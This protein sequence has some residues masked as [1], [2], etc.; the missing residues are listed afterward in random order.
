MRDMDKAGVLDDA[1]AAVKAMRPLDDEFFR[2]VADDPRAVE[3][4]VRAALDDGNIEVESCRAQERVDLVGRR[5]ICADALCRTAD[6][7]LVNVEAQV[8]RQNDDV[9]RVRDHLSMITAAYTA[10][11]TSFGMIP[12]VA[13]VYLAD[14][15]PIGDGLASYTVRR[16][17]LENGRP[18]D[19]GEVSVYANGTADDGSALSKVMAVMCGKVASDY[20]A[21]PALSERV[22]FIRNDEE[23]QRE[24]TDAVEA[25]LES[26]VERR[27][28]AILASKQAEAYREGREEGL[29]KGLEKGLEQGLEQ[30]Q[31]K[32]QVKAVLDMFWSGV[33]PAPAAAEYLRGLG[34]EDASAL[35]DAGPADGAQ[36]GAPALE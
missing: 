4:I 28:D 35:L 5:S 33:I 24:M 31:V 6:G 20:G 8:G 32:G 9:R 3:E 18:L 2:H 12:D 16:T 15:D 14:Y 34:V 11:G 30:G 10:K 17:V 23:V 36:A 1:R 27:V 29:E 26:S 21:C 13:V 19:D 22:D 7:R 25:I